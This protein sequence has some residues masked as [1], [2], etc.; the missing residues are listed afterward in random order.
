[1]IDPRIESAIQEAVED[2]GQP[3][4]VADRIIKWFEEVANGNESLED[5]QDYKRRLDVIFDAVELHE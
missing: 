3:K 5:K 2:H 1:M 4:K